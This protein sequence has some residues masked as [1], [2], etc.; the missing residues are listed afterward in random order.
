MADSQPGTVVSFDPEISLEDFGAG[1]KDRFMFNE[2]QLVL[3]KIQQPRPVSA[4]GVHRTV[5]GTLQNPQ[6]VDQTVEFSEYVNLDGDLTYID[7]LFYHLTTPGVPTLTVHRISIGFDQQIATDTVKFWSTGFIDSS[8]LFVEYSFDNVTWFSAGAV[9]WDYEFN[10]TLALFPGE[11]PPTGQYVY[12]G[13][14]ATSATAR[15]WRIRSDAETAWV[16]GTGATVTVVSTANFPTSGKVAV[17][18][19]TGALRGTATYT[20]KTST[21]FTGYAGTAPESGNYFVNIY[22]P[23]ATGVT[24]AR[25]I[26]N[27]NP[28]LQHWNSDG[29]Q[30][31]T[32]AVQGEEF[33]DITYDKSEDAYYAL[34]LSRGLGLAAAISASDN[35]NS[36]SDSNVDIQRWRESETNSY[37]QRNTLSGTLDHKSAGGDGQLEAKFAIDGNFVSTIELVAAVTL[38]NSS[39]FFAL[40]AKDY[41]DGNQYMVSTLKGPYIPGTSTA[42]ARFGGAVL[43]YNDTVAGAARLVDFRIN[44]AGFNFAHSGGLVEYAITYD[45][46]VDQYTVVASG[47]T[48]PNAKPGVPYTI[49]SATFTISNVSTPADGQGFIVSARC[50][51]ANV[52]GTT[53]S[54]ITLGIE[55]A[56]TNSYARYA[57]ADSPG[58]FEPLVNGNI[59]STA[60][61]RPQIYASPGGATINV[62]AD[63]FVVTGGTISYD[64]PVFSVVSIDKNGNLVQVTGVSDSD[65][66]VIKS[67][68]LIREVDAEYNTYLAPITSIA[69]NGADSGNGG[70]I[71]LKFGTTLYKYLKT[72]LPIT[73]NETGA[74]ASITTTGE[75][76][77]TGISAF[78]YNG[79]TQAG[80]SYIEFEE[81]LDGVFLKTIEHTTLEATPY[82]AKLDISSIN[83][84]FAWNVS[85]LSTLYYV[86]G[87]DLKL[88]D[89]NETK[90]AFVVVTSDKQVLAAGTGESAVVSAQVL[91]IYGEPKSAKSMTFTVSAGDGALSPASG[92]S[93]GSGIDTTT[94]TVGSSV[95]T[96]SIT[97]SVSDTVCVP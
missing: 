72:A 47:I 4:V 15:Y 94:Y 9:T 6:D 25:I 14:L 20:G 32:V 89:L 19:D 57:D 54:G 88:Y 75:I 8:L 11:S 34:R 65:G 64:T 37:F 36:G 3:A 27:I 87:T 66:Y 85:D 39:S 7:N 26:Q 77:E 43:S 53:A 74:S 61:L 23:F 31:V 62:G 97:V 49:D 82:K 41:D 90:A 48:K 51:Q 95:G 86:D 38:T 56:G 44:P 17:V 45:E 83:Y 12:T 18:R 80:L 73:S 84:P 46:D 29:S 69:C 13:E 55:R 78:A 96:A 52:N 93:N 91:N 10:D 58:S 5:S 81:D 79:F 70:A 35:F 71:Y 30:A 50:A 60:T 1:T 40:E 68:D 33:Y 2:N 16:S 28:I 92:C 76:P 59:S 22:D 42:S 24:E 67:L 63:N 21:T